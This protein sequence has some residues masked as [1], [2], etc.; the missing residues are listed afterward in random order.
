M[1]R[2]AARSPARASSTP[3]VIVATPRR[4]GRAPLARP[5]GGRVPARGR[6]GRLPGRSIPRCASPSRA[7]STLVGRGGELAVLSPGRGT[8]RLSVDS[9][10]RGRLRRERPTHRY[11][12]IGAAACF[13][14]DARGHAG[15][16]RPTS[17]RRSATCSPGRRG[18]GPATAS[19][20]AS[21]GPAPLGGLRLRRRA[22]RAQGHGEA[23]L[24]ARR[25]RRRRPA[26][27]TSAGL[28][29]PRAAPRRQDV[30]PVRRRPPRA[31]RSRPPAEGDAGDGSW[32][33]ALRGKCAVPGCSCARDRRRH[34]PRR[35]ARRRA[36]RDARV[37]R[38]RAVRRPAPPGLSA[39]QG[40]PLRR[41]T[42]R[43]P[44]L[45]IA[46]STEGDRP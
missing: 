7:S 36:R 9:D 30:P 20:S 13:A 2:C 24:P 32:L 4:G 23:A 38:H 10:G 17:G 8:E 46:E 40:R 5:R 35:A 26:L 21:T 34:R 19:D 33:G 6:L 39:G 42:K 43:D 45:R 11:W 31:A 14:G 18:S 37:P 1:L 29:A 44:P 25:A 12:Y 41:R 27:S 28:A 16:W 3:A 22:P 15:P